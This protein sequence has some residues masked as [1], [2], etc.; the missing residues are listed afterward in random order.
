MKGFAFWSLQM[1]DSKA[2]IFISSAALF[3]FWSI[4]IPQHSWLFVVIT[5]IFKMKL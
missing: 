5:D 4:V 2:I 1:C 3:M